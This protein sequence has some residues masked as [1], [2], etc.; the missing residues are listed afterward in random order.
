MH[1]SSADQTA[2]HHASPAPPVTTVDPEDERAGKF[3]G[4]MLSLFFA[5]TVVTSLYVLR[6]TWLSIQESIFH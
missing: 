6:W 3:L 2:Q 4:S 1:D 5:Y